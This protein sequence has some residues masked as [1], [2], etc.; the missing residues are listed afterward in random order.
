MIIDATNLLVGRMATR[1]AK[2]ALLGEA[3]DIV[4]CEKA[5]ISGNKK[6]ILEKYMN[7]LQRGEI[8]KGPYVYR[9]P[10]LFVKRV[11]RGMLPRKRAR[12]REALSRIMC[13]I[14]VP[15]EL[16]NKKAD[17][18]TAADYSKLPNHKIITVKEICSRIGWKE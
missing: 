3:I 13:H 10:D 18:I 11:I 1:V 15:E 4:N 16:K 17:T 14:G 6:Q 7:A 2:K 8:R 5:V 12:G 9:K